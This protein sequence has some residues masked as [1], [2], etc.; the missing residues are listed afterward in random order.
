[1]YDYS[2]NIAKQAIKD[3]CDAYKKFFNGKANKPKFKSKKRN[4]P[5]FYQDTAKIKFSDTHV[6]IEKVGW[7]LLSE[8]GEIPVQA[9]YVNPRVT[10][11][12]VHGYISVSFEVDSPN[13]ALSNEL[14]GMD[15]GVKYFVVCSNGTIYPNV[16]QSKRLKRLE[17]RFRRL[18][19]KCSRKYE[20]NKIQEE[21]GV[22]RYVKTRN[23]T[24]LETQ[25]QKLRIQMKN[26]RKDYEKGS[27]ELVRTKPARIIMEDLNIKGI[28][29]NRH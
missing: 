29:K 11:D 17:K 27:N 4:K 5:S 23:M 14:L 20:R 25:M 22:I 15:V 26:I 24:K 9:K 2:N 16:T 18:Q 21:G 28:M 3:L 10:F 19:R 12:G 13:E 1:L 7:I 8:K 6:Y